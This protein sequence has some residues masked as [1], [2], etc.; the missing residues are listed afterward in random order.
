[1][2]IGKNF[3]SAFSDKPAAPKPAEPVVDP[4]AKPVDTID[5]AD[6][7]D[8]VDPVVDPVVDPA[9]PE[10]KPVDPEPKPVDP[11]PK[12]VDPKPVDPEP[13]VN[14]I[15]DEAVLKYFKEKRGKEF[16]SLDDFFKDPEPTADPFEGLSEEA[17]QFLKYNKE[18]NRGFDEFKTLNRDYSKTNPAELAREK[19]IAMSDGYLDSSN[20][21][22][23]LEDELKLDV[24]DFD[25]L[26]PIEKMKLK[27]YGADYLKSQIELK[28]KYKKPA[29][30]KGEVEMV[31]LENGEKMPKEKYEKLLNQQQVYQKSIQESSDNIKVSAYDIK[32]DDNGTEKVMNVG[33]EYTKEEVRDM[34]S[35][36]LDI[37]GFYQKAF[38]SDKGL[39]YGKLQ[40]GLHWANPAK[41]EKAITAIV[42]KAL[43]QQAE[44]FAAIEHNAGP[45]TKS[46]P[47]DGSSKSKASITD[48]RS[49]QGQ[50]KGLGGLTPEQF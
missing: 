28:E 35:S 9:D 32:I 46:M 47:G 37:D 33:Y 31:S 45:K 20:V 15:N 39:D 6:P 29:E 34:A 23:Y 21:D 22:D 2:G 40:E 43:A 42:H 7:A 10:P 38:G 13:T 5:P 49:G 12:P 4:N 24:S 17:A 41:R 18:T 50:G 48:W 44:D 11:E 8:P 16:T 25:S 30:R 1:M 14:E 36:A 26:S 27:N 19:A 3:L